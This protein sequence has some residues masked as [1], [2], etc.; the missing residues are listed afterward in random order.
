MY[1]E[2]IKSDW[3]LRDLTTDGEKFDATV[4]GDIHDSLFKAGLI[5]NPDID[6]N[7]RKAYYVVEHTWEYTTTFTP[8]KLSGETR[9]CFDRIDGACAVFLNGQELGRIENAFRP[10]LFD[11]T[12]LILPTENELRLVFFPITDL[13]KRDD[14]E[15]MPWW[16]ARANLRRTQFNCAMDW[17]LPLPSMGIGAEV[18]IENETEYEII[19]CD[20]K[21]FVSG[22]VDFLFEI[23]DPAFT[24]GD[25]IE[26]T[27]CDQ[28]KELK[29][30]LSLANRRLL[31]TINL[32]EPRLWYP[33]GY[34]EQSL[35]PWEAK[36]FVDGKCCDTKKGRF[37]IREISKVQNPF[38][39]SDE[40]GYSFGLCV[41]GL[42]I[43]CKGGNWVPMEK[44]PG[45]IKDEDYEYYVRMAANANFTMLRVWGGGIYE[46]ERFYELCDEYGILVWQDFMFE[47][48]VY[49]IQELHDEIQK[50]ADYQLRRLRLHP[51]V[52]LWCGCNENINSWKYQRDILWR[53]DNDL[54]IDIVS[55][56]GDDTAQIDSVMHFDRGKADNELF[57]I[58]LRGFVAKHSPNTPYIESSPE[59]L[60]DF[61]NDPTSGNCHISSWKYALFETN[62]NY[63]DWRK[64]FDKVCSFDS[65]FCIQGPCSVHMLKGM[66]SEK[67]HWPPNDI[68]SYR[69]NLGHKKL[70][71]Y[72][73]TLWVAGATIG[74]IDSLQTFV[75]HG[76]ATHVEM[77]RAE[78]DSARFDCPDNGGTL[79]W[80]FN[81]CA[82]TSNWSIIP[83]D[84]VPK[85]SYYSAKRACAPVS[86]ILFARK[87]ILYVAVSNQ[88][89]NKINGNAVFGEQKFDGTIL[90]KASASFEA[91]T[92][93]TVV[94]SQIEL[95][96]LNRDTD[97]YYLD[98][99][100]LP[101]VIYFPNGWNA[102][103]YPQPEF[104]VS[105]KL[106]ELDGKWQM[107]VTVNAKSFI[108][109]FHIAYKDR[110]VHPF[111]SDNYFD[112]T[113]G[114][115]R[116]ITINFDFRPDES[117][118]DFGHWMTDWD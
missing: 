33:N 116:T 18:Y 30:T 59:S 98:I 84:K 110:N 91:E 42:N 51:S 44:W 75:K 45:C 50:E 74:E 64:H 43:F 109:L 67:N 87:G 40:N 10:H 108:R 46:H 19:N 53:Q 118:L 8:T 47:S 90:N 28:D 56:Q 85:P 3:F 104:E 11:V 2:A 63:A 20:V 35:Y 13:G 82:P 100:G 24:K 21:P 93:E 68:W 38:T 34:G 77:M 92:G 17:A 70:P 80:M 88:T 72:L 49:P 106:L 94:I 107:V 6:D 31:T 54:A 111:Y 66:F 1:R 79:M 55:S 115:T 58:W 86:P 113:N 36:L 15:L 37:G 83:Y 48:H 57:G 5:P 26:L 60:T 16:N 22:R 117:M 103:A 52:A 27:I 14:D 23:S 62:G 96:K 61:G 32:D 89:A 95:S 114:E 29:Y 78:F 99:D 73:Q 4:P 76:Q 102:L 65:E 105:T 12:S 9:L 41:N 112:L 25:Y 101:R 81:D 39:K 7:A 97:Y 71:H 69:I